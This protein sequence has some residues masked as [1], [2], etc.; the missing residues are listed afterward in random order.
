MDGVG[1]SD[2]VLWEWLRGSMDLKR[3]RKGE[4]IKDYPHRS[5]DGT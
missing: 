5:R 2:G 1:I 3:L 4:A